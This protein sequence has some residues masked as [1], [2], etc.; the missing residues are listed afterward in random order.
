MRD[1]LDRNGEEFD[2]SAIWVRQSDE[3]GE[4]APIRRVKQGG[5]GKDGFWETNRDEANRDEN[6]NFLQL[7]MNFA[8]HGGSVYKLRSYGKWCGRIRVDTLRKLVIIA[9]VGKIG[10]PLTLDRLQS[11][12]G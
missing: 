10:N 4:G 8:G 1:G 12:A 6:G 7:R 5:W 2:P 11:H 9:V 3:G